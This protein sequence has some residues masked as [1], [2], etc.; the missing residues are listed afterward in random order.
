MSNHVKNCLL[1]LDFVESISYVYGVKG[2][3]RDAQDYKLAVNDAQV[4]NDVSL[5]SSSIKL[6]SRFMCTAACVLL[7][8]VSLDLKQRRYEMKD[9]SKHV[10]VVKRLVKML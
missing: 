9:I 4:Q 10:E 6:A 1:D 8:R 7:S 2:V 5:L 3:Y